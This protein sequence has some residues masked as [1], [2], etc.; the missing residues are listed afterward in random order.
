MNKMPHGGGNLTPHL[1]YLRLVYVYNKGDHLLWPPVNDLERGIIMKNVIAFTLATSFSLSSIAVT[2]DTIVESHV[3][4][5]GGRMIGGITAFLIGGLAGPAGSLLALIPGAWVGENAQ[6]G[7]G[8]SGQAYSIKK[9]NGEIVR[10][11]SPNHQFDLGDEVKID[12]IR[13][14]PISI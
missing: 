8:L 3:D 10:L 5:T 13:P 7:L 12:G 1:V 2:A 4:N 6:E 14:K 11:R 9:E